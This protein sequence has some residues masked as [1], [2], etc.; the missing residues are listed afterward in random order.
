MD[1]EKITKALLTAQEAQRL[2][3]ETLRELEDSLGD[4]ELDGLD[5][6]NLSTYDTDD[7]IARFKD[8]E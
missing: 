3:W 4:G 6:L 1:R 5:A 2:F 8:S 7:I